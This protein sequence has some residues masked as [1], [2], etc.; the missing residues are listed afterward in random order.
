MARRRQPK[1]KFSGDNNRKSRLKNQKAHQ[2]SVLGDNFISLDRNDRATGVT[3]MAYSCQRVLRADGGITLRLTRIGANKEA[4]GQTHSPKDSNP[5]QGDST[6]LKHELDMSTIQNIPISEL[7]ERLS[8][9]DEPTSP[10]T[11]DDIDSTVNQESV[12]DVN[13]ESKEMVPVLQ[14]TAPNYCRAQPKQEHDVIV[15][16]HRQD[17]GESG[18]VPD[19][20]SMNLTDSKLEELFDR[21]VN[22]RHESSVQKV[23][24]ILERYRNVV[25]DENI[26]NEFDLPN[27]N[28][29]AVIGFDLRKLPPMCI[30]ELHRLEYDDRCL[31]RIENS[32]DHFHVL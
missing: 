1:R 12:T 31:T 11:Y 19:T 2:S 27:D 30:K 3:E 22:I 24:E 6:K 5:N 8:I 14:E 28:D 17:N 29:F 9:D 32:N 10:M 15:P 23:I 13:C 26:I 16:N 4:K 21:L 18:D 25:A 7:L 20:N